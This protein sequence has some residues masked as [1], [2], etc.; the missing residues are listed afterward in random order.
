MCVSCVQKIY[1]DFE[2]RFDAIIILR[3]C[4]QE[5]EILTSYKSVVMIMLLS[6]LNLHMKT[7]KNLSEA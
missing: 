3:C 5:L 6:I 7:G 2:I 1:K 4:A